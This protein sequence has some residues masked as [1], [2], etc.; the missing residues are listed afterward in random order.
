M[1]SLKGGDAALSKRMHERLTISVWPAPHNLEEPL[2]TVERRVIRHWTPPI[3]LAENPSSAPGLSAARS[4][5][6]AEA[7]GW[8]PDLR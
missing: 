3:D 7:R 4:A 6:A 2:A 5:M 8:T 1:D